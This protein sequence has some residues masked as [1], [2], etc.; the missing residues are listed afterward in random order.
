[1]AFC[2]KY[3]V[4][5]VI[6]NEGFLPNFQFFFILIALT[7]YTLKS[8]ITTLILISHFTF[9]IWAKY[10][11]KSLRTVVSE[12]LPDSLYLVLVISSRLLISYLGQYI[13]HE[14][15][16]SIS[17]AFMRFTVIQLLITLL[18]LNHL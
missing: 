10:K 6:R 2:G 11:P 3:L 13:L 4:V 17:N 15:T 1:M 14:A 5:K 16:Y 7:V 18:W 8:I 9:W 12:I